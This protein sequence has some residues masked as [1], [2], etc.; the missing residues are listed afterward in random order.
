MLAQQIEMYDVARMEGAKP[1]APTFF[2]L[3]KAFT[4]LRRAT[5]RL[6]TMPYAPVRYTLKYQADCQFRLKIAHFCHWS[7]R[8]ST[9]LGE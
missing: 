1:R 3:G 9:V 6:E 8:P 4:Q 2:T 7:L 5:P